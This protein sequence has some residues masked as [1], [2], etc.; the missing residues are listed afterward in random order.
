LQSPAFGYAYE[1][2]PK[3]PV[4]TRHVVDEFSNDPGCWYLNP[5]T[6]GTGSFPTVSVPI[7]R[8]WE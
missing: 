8:T 4:T 1:A 6:G 2:N 5:L 3:A 7:G